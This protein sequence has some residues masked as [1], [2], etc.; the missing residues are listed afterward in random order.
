MSDDSNLYDYRDLIQLFDSCFFDKFNTKLVKGQYEPIY[1][2]AGSV[3]DEYPRQNWHQ[4][5][6]AHG[7]FRS[8]LHEVA[9]WLV[10]GAAR[11]HQV[12]YG[13]WYQADGRT[14]SEQAIFEQV[15]VKP[16]A[17]EWVLT[18]AC[19]HAFS[20]SVDNLEGEAT[21]PLPFKRA[22]Y[23]QVLALQSTG[24]NARAERFRWA[25]AQHYGTALSFADMHFSVSEL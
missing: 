10:A 3:V 21:D 1:I 8:A 5:L 15:E 2:P 14:A 19:G 23:Q 7:F 6:F 4:I 12:D 22:V 18:Q 24:L 25:L 13:Y 20:V 11:R 17:I 16:Q 9:H